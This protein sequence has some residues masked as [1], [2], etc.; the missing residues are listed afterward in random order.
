MKTHP[1]VRPIKSRRLTMI[2]RGNQ[3]LYELLPIGL[4]W[5]MPLPARPTRSAKANIV[6][7]PG[8][9]FPSLVVESKSLAGLSKRKF[10]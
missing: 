8:P 6:P 10:P 2:Q 3:R 7:F 4:Q 1:S 5:L 9:Q